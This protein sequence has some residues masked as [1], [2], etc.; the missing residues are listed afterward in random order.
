MN[1]FITGTVIS[2]LKEADKKYSSSWIHLR[3]IEFLPKAIRRQE[4]MVIVSDLAELLGALNKH[5]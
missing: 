5:S 3:C 4:D 2:R 1:V